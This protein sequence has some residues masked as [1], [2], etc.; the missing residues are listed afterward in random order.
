MGS[1]PARP[2]RHRS[3]V[4]VLRQSTPPNRTQTLAEDQIAALSRLDVALTEETQ[5]D[6][7]Y[8]SAARAEVCCSSAWRDLYPA[9]NAAGSPPRGRSTECGLNGSTAP[10]TCCP[11]SS[12]GAPAAHCSSLLSFKAW[13]RQGL[14]AHDPCGMPTA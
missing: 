9:D 7:L 8:E 3:V 4:G 1:G 2:L 11:T 13:C 10:P 12:P 5:W 14:T 6:M